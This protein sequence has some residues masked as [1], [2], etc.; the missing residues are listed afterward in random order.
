MKHRFFITS[1]GTGIGKSFITAALMRQAKALGQSVMAYK[2]VISGFNSADITTNDTGL[3]LKSL[4]LPCTSENIERVSP[5]RYAAPL[6]PSMA[7]RLEG[8]AVDFHA[9]VAHSQNAFH[10]PED[11]VLIEGVGGVM[12]PINDQRLVLDWIEVLGVSVL[13]VVGTYLGSISHTLTAISILRQR[14]IPIRA[15][16]INESEGSSVSMDATTDEL[17][18]WAD[19]PLL[20]VSRR[21][22][23]DWYDVPELQNLL[24]SA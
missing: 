15:V 8:R 12:V 24:V 10:E 23:F 4:D 16:V 1:S 19:A 11:V 5:W 9:L 7:G 17:K 6:A 14:H 3:I 21:L 20:P 2:P 18:L 13:L 22:N